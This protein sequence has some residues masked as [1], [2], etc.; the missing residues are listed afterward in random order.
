MIILKGSVCPDEEGFK[1]FS[2]RMKEY[3]DVFEKATGEE[4]RPGTLNVNVGTAI[5]IKEHFRIHGKELNEPEEFLFEVCRING[6]WAYRIRPLD[7]MGG[8]GHGDHILEITC[9]QE[10]PNCGP[11]TGVEIALFPRD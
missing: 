8:G 1:H 3:P 5:P 2:R 9:S 7:A 10:I 6:M 11:G 4:L